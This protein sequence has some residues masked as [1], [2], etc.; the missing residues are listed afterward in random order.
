MKA[1]GLS[2]EH[3]KYMEEI[4]L[5][6]GL[7][8]GAPV[9]PDMR[10][11]SPLAPMER[12]AEWSRLDGLMFDTWLPTHERVGGRLAGIA[13]KGTVFRGTSL[14]GSDGPASR[15]RSRDSTC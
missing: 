9:R 15:S 13:P 12:Y 11:R 5:R 7:S 3:L 10:E 1:T 14:T 6:H 2:A 8:P 4:A